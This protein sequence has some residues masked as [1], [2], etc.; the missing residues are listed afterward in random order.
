MVTN[1]TYLYV[2]YCLPIYNSTLLLAGYTFLH[3]Q[4]MFDSCLLFFVVLLRLVFLDTILFA[5]QSSS[6]L[7]RNILLLGF[8]TRKLTNPW[9]SFVYI[10]SFIYYFRCLFITSR[11]KL[12]TIPLNINRNYNGTKY[13]SVNFSGSGI[14]DK[15]FKI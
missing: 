14:T 13:C 1:F 3:P 6:P 9:I 12:E 7:R 5:A 15:N 4:R 10:H 8:A 11:I 2:P